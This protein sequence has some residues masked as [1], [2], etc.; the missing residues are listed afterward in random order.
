MPSKQ[1][2]EIKQ[3]RAKLSRL[4]KIIR[5]Y[6]EDDGQLIPKDIAEIKEILG[7][8]KKR[9]G[10]FDINAIA[11][12]R[13]TGNLAPGKDAPAARYVTDEQRDKVRE[14]WNEWIATNAQ[15]ILAFNEAITE[16]FDQP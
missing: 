3:L 16:Y 10:L 1:E 8:G 9:V 4:R 11:F 2:T 15:I 7:I 14:Q 5:D 13:M 12:R 6:C